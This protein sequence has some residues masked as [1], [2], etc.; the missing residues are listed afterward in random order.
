MSP[1]SAHVDLTKTICAIATPPGRGGLGIV[2]LSGPDAIAIA[3][4]IFQGRVQL[5]GQDGYTVHHGFA[6]DWRTHAEID[7]VLATLF[8]APRSYTGE[9]LVEFSAHGG[10]LVLSRIVD[11]CI[12]AEAIPAQPGE[13]TL[14]AFLNGRI[15][16]TEAEAV[17]DLIAA[18][19]DES[20][21]AAL[22]QLKGQL[23]EEILA[24]R[25]K[26]IAALARLEI[27]ID[28]TEEDIAPS[29]IAGVKNRI[30]EVRRRVL[31]L[32]ASYDRGRVLREGFTVV[33]AGPPNSGK[34][35][36]FNR[37]AQD[38]RA[39]VTDIPG[40]T[41]DILREYINLN[42]W[43][44]C[45]LD[46]AGMRES[47][48]TVERIGVE[49]A[50]HA[51]QEADGVIWLIDS[52]ADVTT[53]LPVI[54]KNP[55]RSPWVIC[56]NKSDISSVLSI[57]V[58]R[59]TSNSETAH[60]HGQRVE[61]DIGRPDTPVRPGF[62]YTSVLEISAKTGAGIDELLKTITTWI[63]PIGTGRQTGTFAINNRHRRALQSADA[64]LASALESLTRT[65]GVELAAFDARNAALHLGE[66]IG[67]TTTEDVLTEVFK[68]FCIGK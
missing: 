65:D 19:T 32:L 39:I 31:H 11:A 54:D 4:R 6:V 41:R 62:E 35:T 37:L 12:T 48:D 51:I 29:E 14:R 22:A 52:T 67:E 24:L 66:I 49:R 43:P 34:S 2:R 16:L 10:Q 47:S 64:A 44:V 68:N 42:G 27:G 1:S 28:F 9:H 3:D 5:A 15:D 50:E 25:A 57:V 53:Q 59:L 17:A 55:N 20:S 61:R 36:L 21:A 40:T 13:F 46:T 45:I 23:H 8:R 58:Q 7:E 38:E 18:K 26:I 33:L 56:C 30:G 63:E 60:E